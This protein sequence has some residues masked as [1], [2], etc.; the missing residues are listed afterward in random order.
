MVIASGAMT[1]LTYVSSHAEFSQ[2]LGLAHL[3]NSQELTIVCAS[4]FG[5]TLGFL[6]YNCHPAE[7]F[8]GDVG[9]LALGGGMGIVA[10]LI[11]QEVLLRLHRRRVCHR[12]AL[13]HPAGGQL[14]IARRQAHL[15][16]GADSPSF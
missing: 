10:V 7:V 6:W 3:P 14:Q 16:D 8:M 9:S 11:K 13:R 1:V 2:Y 12:S 4:M 5:A 15:Q